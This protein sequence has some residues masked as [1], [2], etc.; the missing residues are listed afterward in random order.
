MTIAHPIQSH[1]SE[2]QQVERKYSVGQEVEATYRGRITF[3]M[4]LTEGVTPYGVENEAGERLYFA[5]ADI[6]PAG[7]RQKVEITAEM[8][9][10]ALNVWHGPHWHKDE[11]AANFRKWMRAALEK[12]INGGK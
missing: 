9:E 11:S 10:R 6:R 3:V 1:E 2:Q 5:E 12:A 7:E 4:T 8:V